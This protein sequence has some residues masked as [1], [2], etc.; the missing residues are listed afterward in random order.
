MG[1]IID[2]FQKLYTE[3]F[4]LLIIGIV[5]FA[6]LIAIIIVLTHI[7]SKRKS[8][9]MFK[10]NEE[11]A[12]TSLTEEEIKNISQNVADKEELLKYLS[13]KN[14][15]IKKEKEPVE[16]KSKAKTQTKTVQKQAVESEPN[17][18]VEP[19]KD[20][21]TKEVAKSSD[22]KPVQKKKP[23]QQ[24]TKKQAYTGKWKIKKEDT[25][26]YSELTASNGGLL[27]RTETY[28]SLTG[29]KNGIT[30]IKKNIDGGNFVI[31][32]DKYGHYRFKL[33]SSSN[34]LICVSEDYSSK[35]KC[36]SGIESVKRFAKTAS[37]IQE[38]SD[39]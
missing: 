3:Y 7:K 6:V 11:K 19:L 8:V 15:E 34:R 25:K 4:Y 2:F 17:K 31:S 29:V 13:E 36:E 24:T 10:N 39:N 9:E 18:N 35:A 26:F 20:T 16:K 5:L 1:K 22:K 28:T 14:V 37:I 12:I 30:T 38:E 32:L 23:V 33:Y 21:S 27:L